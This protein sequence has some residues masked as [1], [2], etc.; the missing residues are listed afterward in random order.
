MAN[1]R[2][3]AKCLHN[4]TW[5]KAPY[6]MTFPKEYIYSTFFLYLNFLKSYI[7]NVVY[8]FSDWS[9]PVAILFRLAP[10]SLWFSKSSLSYFLG[11]VGVT[12]GF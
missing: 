6:P 5:P 9:S 1:S 11:L 12:A 4:R 10:I 7:C 2:F 3:V 8:V